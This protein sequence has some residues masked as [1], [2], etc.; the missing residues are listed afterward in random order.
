MVH[1]LA[2]DECS[3]WFE[4]SASKITKKKIILFEIVSPEPHPPQPMTMRE[5]I[6]LKF[7]MG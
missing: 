4:L 5:N 1:L 3:E 2:A 7:P 6:K